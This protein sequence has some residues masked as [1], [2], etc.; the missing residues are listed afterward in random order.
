MKL[1]VELIWLQLKRFFRQPAILFWAFAF[2][3]IMAWILGTAF[4]RSDKLT[5]SVGIVAASAQEALQIQSQLKALNYTP[6]STNAALTVIYTAQ[7]FPSWETANLA[8][9]KSL[10]SLIIEPTPLRFHFDPTNP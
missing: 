6:S 9:K 5:V 3:L 10:V 7:V 1:L 2:P 4:N 8:I